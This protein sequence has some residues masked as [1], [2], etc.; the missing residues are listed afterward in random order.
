MIRTTRFIYSIV[1]D[2]VQNFLIVNAGPENN[3]ENQKQ[4]HTNEREYSI[5]LCNCN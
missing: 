2:N 3:I 4:T 5:N 1:D